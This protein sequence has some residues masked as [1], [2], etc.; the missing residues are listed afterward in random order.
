MLTEEERMAFLESIDRVRAASMPTLLGTRDATQAIRFVQNLHRS[1]DLA[2][3]HSAAQ[4]PVPDCKAGCDHCCSM[5]VEVTEPE[6]FLIA[7]TVRALPT[8]HREVVVDKL[9]A[10]AAA[11]SAGESAER[12]ECAFLQDKQ[13]SIY[14]VRPGVCRKGHSLSVAQCEARSPQIP[15][16]VS[17]LAESEAL[18]IG[19][20]QA[21]LQVGLQISKQELHTAVLAALGDE[22]AEQRWFQPRASS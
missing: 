10:G 15:Q 1:I 11:R 4:G 5:H 8:H 9:R 22:A 3:A 19:V 14:A 13:C 20:A 17:L 16:V 21:Y 6:A 7:R 18:M 12:S 2:A